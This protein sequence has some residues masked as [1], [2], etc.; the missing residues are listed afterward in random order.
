MGTRGR[1][2]YFGAVVGR[3]ANRI[4]KGK[5]TVDG[6]EYALAINNGVN[7]LHGGVNS[8]SRVVWDWHCSADGRVTFTYCSP[9]MDEG[10]P[11]QCMTQVTY[12]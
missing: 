6:V 2:P 9:H 5:F 12:T 8:F 10:Y 4:G 1:N 7:H 3:V 11:G